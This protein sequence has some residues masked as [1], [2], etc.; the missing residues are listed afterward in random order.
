MLTAGKLWPERVKRSGQVGKNN[1]SNKEKNLSK[2]ELPIVEK[3]FELAP[4]HLVKHSVV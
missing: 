3:S 4:S 1:N 2:I